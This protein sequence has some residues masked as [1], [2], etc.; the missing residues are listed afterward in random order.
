VSEK[1]DIYIKDNEAACSSSL[2]TDDIYIERRIIATT[3]RA[4]KKALSLSLSLFYDEMEWVVGKISCF[5]FC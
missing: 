5:F 4:H 2:S 3:N 1:K